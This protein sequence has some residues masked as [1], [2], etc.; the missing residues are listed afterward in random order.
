LEK[1]GVLLDKFSL[2]KSGKTLLIASIFVSIVRKFLFVCGIMLFHDYPSF[3]IFSFNF[4]VLF[5]IMFALYCDI[6]KD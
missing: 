3:T 1:Y 6:Y 2:H 4:N 5:F